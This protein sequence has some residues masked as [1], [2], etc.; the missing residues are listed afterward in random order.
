MY[1]DTSFAQR[2]NFFRIDAETKRHLHELKPFMETILP[3]A[4][5]AFYTHV[6][7]TPNMAALFRNPDHMRHARERQ[8]QHWQVILDAK[9]DEAYVQSVTKVGQA[10]HRLGL[11]PGWY[12]AG[13]SYLVCAVIADLQTAGHRFGRGLSDD[14]AAKIAAFNRAAMVDMD[15]A[16]SVYLEEGRREKR[17]ALAKV[18]DLFQSSVGAIAEEADASTR[19][20]KTSADRMAAT[21]TRTR[22]HAASAA[23]AAEESTA[24]VGSVA[25]AVEEL[26]AS[27]REIS[28]R[29]QQASSIAT[30]AADRAQETS[31]VVANL[32]RIAEEIGG[33][34]TLIKTIAAQTNLLALNATIEAA[35]AGEAGRGF[36]VVAA[37]VKELA[38]QT[39]RATEDIE[40]QIGTIQQV[41]AQTAGSI[42]EINTANVR[43]NE[44][45]TSI[46]AAVE[47]QSSATGEIS[48]STS[49]AEIGSRQVTE[50]MTGVHADAD[51][52]GAVAGELLTAS[53]ALAREI[54]TLRTE[55]A[56][57]LD[58]VRVA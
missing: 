14:M 49:E 36:A 7:A 48:R 29:V 25:A 54:A 10:H 34:V 52:S 39:T 21:A 6:A 13:Y 43:V 35:R 15:C 55:A 9:F 27:I 11:E 18:A 3:R 28:S 31:N 24:S 51:A 45:F 4:L 42:Q 40:R 30:Q 22:N 46:A 57:F 58:R 20:V 50:A 44:A 33:I 41:T 56:N 17:E 16:I 26:S 8:L 2:L 12:I 47:E 23:S 19:E 5:D 1:Q 32:V 53:A 37:E 38:S